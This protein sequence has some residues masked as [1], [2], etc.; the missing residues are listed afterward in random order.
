MS[1]VD[2]Q[3]DTGVFTSKAVDL[4]DCFSSGFDEVLSDLATSIAKERAGGESVEITDQDIISAA[5]MILRAVQNSDL[6]PDTKSEV[7]QMFNCVSS[8]ASSRF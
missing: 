2:R 3:R 4:I 6:P 8:R 5:K 1:T 7:E